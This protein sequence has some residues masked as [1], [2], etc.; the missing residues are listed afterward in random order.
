MKKFILM[1]AVLVP[2]AVLLAASTVQPLNIKTGLWQVTLNSKISIFPAP[3]TSLYK[4]CVRKE[5]LDQYPFTDPDAKCTSTVVSSTGT[6]MEAHGTC[7]PKVDGPKYDY[8]L[9]LDAPDSEHV[10]G[11]GQLV[12]DGPNGKMDG[13]YSAKATWIGATCPADVN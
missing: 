7:K 10:E 9:R 8:I 4:S 12:I 6:K 1:G 2:A 3:T 11:K 5:D 13:V